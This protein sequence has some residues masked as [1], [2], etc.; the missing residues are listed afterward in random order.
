MRNC[1]TR[2]PVNFFHDPVLKVHGE[3]GWWG[4]YR[5]KLNPNTSY[6]MAEAWMM[7][8]GGDS[9]PTLSVRESFN[10]GSSVGIATFGFDE[11]NEPPTIAKNQ[12]QRN[13]WYKVRLEVNLNKGT[14]CGYLNDVKVKEEYLDK[15]RIMNWFTLD[16]GQPGY[17]GEVR[18]SSW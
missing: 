11:R 6:F 8:G 9:G 16:A 12:V 15:N 10:G 3:H 1:T 4:T 5:Y 2:D 17:F 14:W 13:K 18:I 7:S